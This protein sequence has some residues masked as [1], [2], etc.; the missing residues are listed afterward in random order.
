VRPSFSSFQAFVAFAAGL[1]SV[2]G[3]VYSGIEYLRPAANGEVVAVVEDARTAKPV[4]GGSLEVLTLDDSVIATLSPSD[5]GQMRHELRSGSYRLR[6]RHPRF[7]TE[8][9]QIEVPDGGTVEVHFAL[10]QRADNSGG[11]TTP[12]G[13]ARQ[14]LRHLGF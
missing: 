7:A 12:V 9:R 13:K 6:V 1:I 8:T 4:R 11:R 10:A 2:G 3:A 14:L 5:D